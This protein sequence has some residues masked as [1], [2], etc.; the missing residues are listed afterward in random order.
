MKYNFTVPE[1]KKIRLI[2]NTDAKNEADDQYAFVHALLTPKFIIK[3][4]MAAHFGTRRTEFS[5]EESFSEVKKVL[6][7]MGLEDQVCVT[8]GASLK[9]NLHL[10]RQRAQN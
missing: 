7:M 3:S 5:M 2:I 4:I 6:S 8:K 10:A 9:M 1:E